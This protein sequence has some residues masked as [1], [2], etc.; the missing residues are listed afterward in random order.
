MTITTMRGA[1]MHAVGQDMRIDEVPIPQPGPGDVLVKVHAVNI[2]PNL[3]NILE[4]WTTWF[5]MDPLPTL[6]AVF[7]LDPA[8]TVEAVGADVRHWEIGD[9]VYVNPGRHCGACLACRR[10]DHVNCE[11]YA[12]S[13]YF[14]FTPKSI[15]LL[16]RYPGGLS[17]Y[18]VAPA[19][20]LARLPDRLDFNT[21]ARFGYIGTMYSALRKAGAGPGKTILVNGISGTLGISA[22]LLAPAFGLTTVY[23]SGRNSGLLEEVQAL[24]PDRLKLRSLDDVTLDQWIRSETSG[25]GVDIYIDALGPGAPQETFQAGLRS[26]ARG[27]TAVNIGAVAG[28]VPFDVHWFMDQQMTFRGS[29]W[30]TAAES[31]ELADL[32]AAGALDLTPL[33]HTIYPLT[34]INEAIS[35]VAERHG[36]F[37]NFIIDP[38]AG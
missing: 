4:N 26:L 28:E 16:D 2:V 30:S 23:G 35:G 36:G 11:S 13:G 32:V 1:R 12:F 3:A 27:G 37:S 24:A 7:G 17:E 10:G 21:A 33:E 15:D 14:G 31:Q 19:Y 38:Q 20:S 6:P 25:R 34:K 8:G 18:M 22:A 5:P 9:R 29:A